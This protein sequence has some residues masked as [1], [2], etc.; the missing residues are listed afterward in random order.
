MRGDTGNNFTAK[1]MPSASCGAPPDSHPSI[2]GASSISGM[3]PCRSRVA[4]PA[5]VVRI[6][7]DSK[8]SFQMSQSPANVNGSPSLRMI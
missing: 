6:A 8:P 2:P 1:S 4:L 7:N 5:S 3:R